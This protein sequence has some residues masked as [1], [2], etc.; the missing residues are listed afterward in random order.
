MTQDYRISLD[1]D[2][3]LDAVQA[4]LSSPSSSSTSRRSSAPDSGLGITVLVDVPVR[5]WQGRFQL[6]PP[7]PYSLLPSSEHPPSHTSI[8]STTG[9]ITTP[10]L[11]NPSSWEQL[12]DETA[13][14]GDENRNSDYQTCAP[15]LGCEIDELILHYETPLESPRHSIP[16]HED[17]RAFQPVAFMGAG[18]GRSRERGWWRRPFKV[19]GFPT[20]LDRFFVALG[21]FV[22]ELGEFFAELGRFFAKLGYFFLLE[23][24]N[25]FVDPC[26]FFELVVFI[27]LVGFFADAQ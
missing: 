2:T 10:T 22:V 19:N 15:A 25:F 12:S 20:E 8:E 4:A 23:L 27:E 5:S 7:P 17:H 26:C 16:V 11:P 6:D 1:I 18:P 3:V 21:G 9:I 14:D 24:V 13:N